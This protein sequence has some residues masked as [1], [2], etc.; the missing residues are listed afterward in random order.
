MV[1]EEQR[2]ERRAAR[3][4]TLETTRYTHERQEA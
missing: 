2:D 1:Y 3:G 4:K